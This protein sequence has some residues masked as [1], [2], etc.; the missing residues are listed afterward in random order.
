[1]HVRKCMLPIGEGPERRSLKSP[2][3]SQAKYEKLQN[4]PIPIFNRRVFFI[5]FD[6]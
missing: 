6:N 5:T 1:M 4:N 3:E 2:I